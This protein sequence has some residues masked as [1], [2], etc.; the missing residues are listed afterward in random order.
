MSER[1]PAP[2]PADRA[3]R[4]L[5]DAV[6]ESRPRRP[7][8]GVD[9][10]VPV[11]ATVVIVRDSARRAGSAHDRASRPRLLRRRLGL[12][13]RQ[14]RTRRRRPRRR[15]GDRPPGGH[16][17]DLGRDGRAPG[18][19]CPRTALV[20]GSAPGHSAPHPHVV[21]PRARPGR[22][23]RA[24]ARRGHRRRVGASCGHARPPRPR[25]DHAVPADLDHPARPLGAAGRRGADRR[26]A[27]RRAPP[28][29]DGRAGRRDRTDAALARRRRLR[30]GRRRRCGRG[31]CGIPPPSRAREPAVGVHPHAG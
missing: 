4:A 16:P 18:C 3:F 15:A 27:H 25:R 7:E 28:V 30:R 13:R 5:A 8:D 11:A 2:S 31:G 12:S 20:L 14:A 10:D 22:P 1:P 19:R 23:A 17:R 24:G 26:R 6:L 29:R 9:P 21:L